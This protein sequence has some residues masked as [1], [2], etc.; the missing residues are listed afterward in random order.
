[1]QDAELLLKTGTD[2][3]NRTSVDFDGDTLFVSGQFD[4]IPVVRFQCVGFLSVQPVSGLDFIQ[5][6]DVLA[7]QRTIVDEPAK[8]DPVR[9]Q[10]D[11]GTSQCRM[12][13]GLLGLVAKFVADRFAFAQRP[14]VLQVPHAAHSGRCRVCRS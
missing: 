6:F 13:F 4:L 1:M 11:G 8:F 3:A 7:F 2:I 14:Q 5:R 9:S 10:Q 12:D